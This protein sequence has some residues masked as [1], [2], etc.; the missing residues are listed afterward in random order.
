MKHWL[1][2]AF[3]ALFCGF[4][5]GVPFHAATPEDLDAAAARLAQAGRALDELRDGEVGPVELADGISIYDRSLSQVRSVV[6]Q[7][8]ALENEVRLQILRESADMSTFLAM[9]ES[10]SLGR[11]RPLGLHPEG[12]LGAARARM[13]VGAILPAI[14]DQADEVKARLDA[15]ALAGRQQEEGLALLEDGLAKLAS[16]PGGARRPTPVP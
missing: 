6:L 5:G 7:A 10:L 1:R 3:L 8:G 14:S 11:A 16:A 9:L 2:I 4:A 12:P 13:M 15:I